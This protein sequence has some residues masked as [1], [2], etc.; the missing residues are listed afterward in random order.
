MRLRRLF[1]QFVTLATVCCSL[2]LFVRHLDSVRDF[3]HRTP[4]ISRLIPRNGL[5]A[6][7]SKTGASAGDQILGDDAVRFFETIPSVIDAKR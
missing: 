5:T 4:V 7:T 6:S 3:V 2:F 1:R